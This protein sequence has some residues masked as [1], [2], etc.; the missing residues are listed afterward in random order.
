MTNCACFCDPGR[1]YISIKSN[2]DKVLEL[3][4]DS[5]SWVY[6]DNESSAS[7]RVAHTCWLWNIYYIQW[8]YFYIVMLYAFINLHFCWVTS[9]WPIRLEHQKKR[10]VI[11]KPGHEVVVGQGF[12]IFH[13]WGTEY[14]QL[15]FRNMDCF[16]IMHNRLNV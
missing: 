3:A 9:Y 11:R 15:L 14:M 6:I 16:A 8:H 5:C 7:Q 4:F 13:P 2:L 12:L 1:I 10:A